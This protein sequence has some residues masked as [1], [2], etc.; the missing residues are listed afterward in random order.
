M[1]EDKAKTL[2]V[3]GLL[4]PMPVLRTRR[5]LDSMKAGEKLTITASD[6]ASIHDMPAFCKMA[7]HK[8]LMAHETKGVI[9]F[10][11]EKGSV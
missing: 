1:T 9:I 10:E 6:P 11:V 7:G 2:N 4:C 5:A 8:L 3:T